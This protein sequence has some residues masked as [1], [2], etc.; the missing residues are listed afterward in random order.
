M[1]PVGVVQLFNK[2]GIGFAQNIGVLFFHFT[3]NA[4]AQARPREGMA[5]DHIVRQAELQTDFS[6]FVFEQ[7]TQRFHQLHF[8]GFRQAAHIVVGFD[9]VSLAGFG[10]CGFNHI[11]IDGALGQP[12][13][14]FEFGGFI[15]E[16]IDEGVADD[17]ALGFGVVHAV[18]L[19][20][21]LVFGVDADHLHAHVTGEHFHDLVAF[22]FAQQAVV[23]E[24]A[25]ELVADGFV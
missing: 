9:H 12:I 3:Q 24:H 4:H 14:V 6:H 13:D 23:D 7:L 21:E 1:V 18:E 17:L 25:G 20:E 16:H 22:V 11:R 2:N 15:I 5:V 10:G 8:H 19:A